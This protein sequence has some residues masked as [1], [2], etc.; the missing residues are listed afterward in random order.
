MARESPAL[1]FARSSA[2]GSGD[3]VSFGTGKIGKAAT[4]ELCFGM[5]AHPGATGKARC[6]QFLYATAQV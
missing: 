5:V 1:A 2:D 6:T 4:D 3:F